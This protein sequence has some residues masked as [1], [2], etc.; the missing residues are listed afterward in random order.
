MEFTIPIVDTEIDTSEPGESASNFGGAVAG[1]A[2][3]TGAATTAVYLVNRARSLAG[4]EG[5]TIG[6]GL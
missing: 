1:L 5:D 2:L 4:V 3:L 6:E